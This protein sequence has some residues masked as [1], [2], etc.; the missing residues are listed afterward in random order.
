MN[1]SPSLLIVLLPTSLVAAWLFL[2]KDADVEQRMNKTQ[3]EQRADSARVDRDFSTVMGDKKGK[4]DAEARIEAAKSDIATI[5]KAEASRAATD[6]RA[7]VREDV[8]KFLKQNKD[9]SNE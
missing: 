3:A 7:A 9:G 4:A 8:N 2:S 1:L 6:Q 5:Q